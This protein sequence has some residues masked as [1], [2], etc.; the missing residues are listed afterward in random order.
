MANLRP[1]DVLKSFIGSNTFLG[2]HARGLGLLRFVPTCGGGTVTLFSYSRLN[3]DK[4]ITTKQETNIKII[5]D[6]DEHFFCSYELFV[7]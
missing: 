1:N 2:R 4:Q 7:Q 3:T 6:K 5:K